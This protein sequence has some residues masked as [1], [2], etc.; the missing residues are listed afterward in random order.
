MTGLFFSPEK[1]GLGSQQVQQPVP[2]IHTQEDCARPEMELGIVQKSILTAIISFDLYN[3][4]RRN[5]VVSILQMRK[6]VLERL[7]NYNSDISFK[8]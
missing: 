2:L 4:K 1:A 5:F 3:L 6:L 8:N 7:N